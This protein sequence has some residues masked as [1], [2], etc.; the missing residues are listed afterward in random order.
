MCLVS[1]L[2]VLGTIQI[3]VPGQESKHE[4]S[5]V[6]PVIQSRYR[7]R[8]YVTVCRNVKD[9]SMQNCSYASACLFVYERESCHIEATAQRTEYLGEN[10]GLRLNK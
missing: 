6:Q 10:F 2:N 4:P 7:L 3:S 8:C 1:G 5:V 9:Y